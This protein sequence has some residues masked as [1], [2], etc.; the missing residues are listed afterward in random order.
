MGLMT[1]EHLFLFDKLLNEFDFTLG[2]YGEGLQIIET[3]CRCFSAS[4]MM[5]SWMFIHLWDLSTKS[6][7]AQRRWRT[8]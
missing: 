2:S 7:H 1:N 3:Y 4:A 6:E 8:Y 5:S